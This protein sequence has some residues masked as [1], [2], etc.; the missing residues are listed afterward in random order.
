LIQVEISL[1]SN[2]DGTIAVL[3]SV[4]SSPV[5][6]GRQ[7]A[8]KVESSVPMEFESGLIHETPKRF[9]GPPSSAT[10]LLYFQWV[11]A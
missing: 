5:G 6:H 8:M 9:I 1:A 7:I 4:W 10:S 2:S 11:V 3:A